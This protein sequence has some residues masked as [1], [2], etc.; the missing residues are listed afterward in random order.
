MR[1]ELRRIAQLDSRRHAMTEV[2]AIR[3]QR[4]WRGHKGRGD[5]ALRKKLIEMQRLQEAKEHAAA[6][7]LQR[8]YRGHNGRKDFAKR[9]VEREK[10]RMLHARA[11]QIQRAH[12]NHVAWEARKVRL[13]KEAEAQKLRAVIR[14]QKNWRGVRERQL[15]TIMLGLVQLRRQEDKAARIIQSLCRG[16][17][18]RNFMKAMKMVL[19]AQE[20]RDRSILLLQRIFR[21]YKGREAAEVKFE[22]RKLEVVAK[23]LF[24]KIHTYSG[25][26]AALSAK[27]DAL[28]RSLATDQADEAEL[29]LELDKTMT[30]KSKFHDSARITGAKQRY[31]T[32]YLQVQLAD[33]LQKKR[34]AVAVHTRNLEVAVGEYSEAEK[35]LRIAK[36]ELQPLTEGVERKTKENRVRR[37][38][39]KV[40]REKKAATAIQRHFRGYRVRAAVGEGANR[41]LELFDP[42][43]NR[44]YYYNAWNQVRREVRPLAMDIF[45][46]GFVQPFRADAAMKDWFQ[47]LDELSGSFY[48]YNCRTHEYRWDVPTSDQTRDVFEAQP[49]DQLTQRSTSRRSIGKSAWKELVDSESGVV[50]YHNAQTGESVWSLPPQQV[51]GENGGGL[52]RS[53]VSVGGSTTRRRLRTASS[54]NQQ[55]SL[56]WQYYYGYDVAHNTGLVTKRSEPRSPWVEMFDET[57]ELPYYHNVLTQE[58]RWT[59]PDEFDELLPEGTVPGLSPGHEWFDHQDKEQLSSR[60]HVAKREIG[61]Q[62]TEYVDIDT[63]H[64][65]Y[66]NTVTGET[67]WSLSPR[68]AREDPPIGAQTRMPLTLKAKLASFN[69]STPVEYDGRGDHVAWLF[70]SIEA[71]EWVKA[72][73]ILEEILAKEQGQTGWQYVAATIREDGTHQEAYW[74][75]ATTGESAPG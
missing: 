28:R 20:R 13:V 4:L 40:R 37:L 45:G 60:S 66:F 61:A 23:P 41:W 11:S 32:R 16:Y 27:V 29:A 26:V 2:A 3:L 38:Q 53:Q 19:A 30:I 64:A 6:S 18:S 55:P 65:Y 62:W 7:Y 63:G 35:Q 1:D 17:V 70:D 54:L 59:K 12:R 43:T 34:M 75:N 48:F 42:T 49:H 39:V 67:R 72:E 47:C 69:A 24:I 33:Q 52:G 44:K 25:R 36:R 50:Y 31:L 14:I 51:Y 5:V 10:V 71:K 68:S 57:Y 73:G 22:L 46:D 15:G 58:Y 21:G 56:Q 74:Y 8:I 9:L